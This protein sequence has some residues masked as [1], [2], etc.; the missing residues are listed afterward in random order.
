MKSLSTFTDET[1]PGLDDAWDFLGTENNDSE[2]NDYWDID[3][4]TSRPFFTWENRDM[5]WLGN[6]SAWD[7]TNNWDGSLGI[8]TSVKNVII[9]NTAN[10]PILQSGDMADCNNLTIQAGG[11]LTLQSGASLITDGSITNNGTFLAQHSGSSEYW[12]YV[13]S[14]VQGATA[15]I[16]A[17][18]FL[19]SYIESAAPGNHYT[20]ITNGATPLNVCQG[21]A[22]RSATKGSFTFNGTPYT[23]NQEFTGMTT[24]DDY[25]WNLLGNPYPSSLDWNLLDDTYGAVYTY[26]QNSDDAEDN[27]IWRSYNNGGTNGGVRYVPPMQGF[28]IA[29]VGETTFSLTNDARVHNGADGFVKSENDLDNYVLLQANKGSIYDEVLIQIGSQYDEGFELVNDAWKMGVESNDRLLLFTKCDDGSLSIDRR[30]ET[31]MIQLGFKYPSNMTASISTK[32]SADL[33]NMIIEDTK[34]NL[35]H[36]LTKGDYFFDWQTTD[37]EERFILHLKATGTEETEAQDA[38]VYAAN[39]QVYVRMSEADE[40]DEIMI[41]DLAGRIV[42]EDQLESQSIQYFDLQKLNGAYLVQLKGENNSMTQ[43]IIL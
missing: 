39:G 1:T 3:E 40:F 17:G 37:S 21:Y 32:E 15:S 8:P 25:G 29:A 9:P 30:P 38:Q 23:G 2:S 6:S 18:D 10:D 22:W 12:H 14:P 26:V 41:F 11:A 42:Y 36:D 27:Y 43:K 13:S 7:N 33:A 34:L 16:F 19:Q 24:S 4:G 28:F 5:T 20:E 35:F 31:E